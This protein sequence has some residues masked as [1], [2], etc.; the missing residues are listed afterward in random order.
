MSGGKV[1]DFRK[2]EPCVESE[3]WELRRSVFFVGFMGAGKTSVARKLARRAGIAS[4][5]MDTY[6]ERKCDMK[7]KQIFADPQSEAARKLVFPSNPFDPS[8]KD[9]RLI[10]LVFDGLSAG[11][12]FIAELVEK[13]G[14]KVNILSANTRSVGGIGYGQMVLELP[15][16]EEEQ[17][18]GFFKDRGLSVQ[19]VKHSE[20][21]H[22]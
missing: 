3:A 4:V 15:K 1:F 21:L 10:R 5:D 9:S 6:I 7:V 12:P 11:R 22:S 13:T 14:H 8:E 18:I 19:E 20:Q 2:K 17:I 16:G